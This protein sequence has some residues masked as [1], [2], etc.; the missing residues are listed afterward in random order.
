MNVAIIGAGNIAKPY[1]QSLAEHEAVR[2]VGVTD[3]DRSKAAAL[4]AEIGCDVLDSL[5][6]VLD[7]GEV[8]I[9]VNLTVH[10]VHYELNKRLLEADKHV[11]SEKPLAT[12]YAQAKELAE[13]A[14]AK[15][16]RLSCSPFTPMG[17]AQQTAWKAVRDGR[18]GK[19]RLAYAEVNWGRI[20][21]WHPN[22]AP[23]YEVGPLFDVG[24][25]PLTL[26]TAMFG[27]AKSVLAYGRVLLAERKD[28][29]G[30]PFEVK[31][32]DYITSLI[33]LTDDVLVRLTT[34]FYVSQAHNKQGSGVTIHGDKGTV[35]LGQW[36]YPDASVEAAPYGQPFEP[37]PLL[38]DPYELDWGLGVKE[39]VAAIKEGR[40]ERASGAQAAHVVEILE[41]VMVS[42]KKGRSVELSSSFPRPEPMP[43]AQ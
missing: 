42:V 1:A 4:A 9:A 29:A 31:S 25:Y 28:E 40:P 17:P 34:N 27:P 2:L 11:Y 5:E 15:G 20:E 26:L 7:N 14:E 18:V 32:P 22:P 39:L 38:T 16:L 13:L 23:F 10:R 43:W 6:S 35:H 30:Q 33:E 8:D 24:V 36:M 41:A 37:L 3:L 19:P 12:S 21:T